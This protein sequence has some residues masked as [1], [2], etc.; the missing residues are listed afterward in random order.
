MTR[1]SIFDIPHLK[2]EVTQYLSCKDLAQCVLVSRAWFDWFSQ[3]LWSDLNF[4]YELLSF[5]SLPGLIRHADHV[6]SIS[7]FH[8]YMK[9][10]PAGSSPKFPNLQSLDHWPDWNSNYGENRLLQFISA[11]P[12]LQK[13]VLVVALR[14]QVYK[15]LLETL[16]SLPGLKSLELNCY[17]I[18]DPIVTQNIVMACGRLES[19]ESLII[20]FGQDPPHEGRVSD[21]VQN[22]AAM[23]SMSQMPDTRIQH[24]KIVPSHR[25]QELAI[26]VPLV[27]RCPLLES[28]NLTVL[29]HEETLGQLTRLFQDGRCPHL[30]KL[31][32]GYIE[33]YEN[34]ENDLKELLRHV[35][36]DVDTQGTQNGLNSM[37]A[38]FG[39]PLVA[40]YLLNLTQYHAATLRSLNLAQ[41]LLKVGIFFQFVCGLPKLQDLKAAIE[42]DD[43]VEEQV[44]METVV[45]TPWACLDLKS[46]ELNL[47]SA[48]CKERID[49]PDWKDSLP[50]RVLS[51]LFSQ[52]GRLYGLQ[53]W[54]LQTGDVNLL[55]LDLSYLSSLTELKQL[56][57]ITIGLLFTTHVQL[58]EADAEWMMLHWS[59]LVH[60]TTRGNAPLAMPLQA[61]DTG[62]EKFNQRLVALR[63][64]I[65]VD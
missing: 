12:S 7:G 38:M 46:L 64:W 60:V 3:V 40:P 31:V 41:Q 14:P 48:C 19:L 4:D 1:L 36:S 51:Y 2:D 26:L 34:V 6:R 55:T 30:N 9:L 25:L 57:W 35:G 42:M 18:V 53:E 50:D 5:P 22:A 62:L 21:E 16:E 56:R 33:T 61:S 28:L 44:D 45:K 13:I 15:L 29:F 20:S 54:N 27:Q 39:D 23:E 52:I 63:P 17:E 59:R 49:K 24:L 11:T 32:I 43:R 47:D 58:K 65:E 37:T 10:I 8:Q